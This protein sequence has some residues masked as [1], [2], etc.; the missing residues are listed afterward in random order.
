MSLEYSLRQK[1][2]MCLCP[3]GTQQSTEVSSEGSEYQV[4]DSVSLKEGLHLPNQVDTYLNKA[5]QAERRKL[6]SGSLSSGAE[7]APRASA[8][9]G[10]CG[11]ITT[12]P[13]GGLGW[14]MTE[15]SRPGRS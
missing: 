12:A 11:H 10:H 4:W 7:T 6:A 1:A 13:A 9:P 2:K 3:L 5:R 8:C 14:E 15:Q